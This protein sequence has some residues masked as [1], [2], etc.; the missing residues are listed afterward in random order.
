MTDGHDI[1]FLESPFGLHKPSR[2]T[3]LRSYEMR[4]SEYPVRVHTMGLT[5]SMDG[6]SP[7]ST[8]P[9]FFFRLIARSIRDWRDRGCTI[10][11]IVSFSS[12]LI[13]NVVIQEK[14]K[15]KREGIIRR[16]A[17]ADVAWRG[18]VSGGGV[19][20]VWVIMAMTHHSRVK[21]I[22]SFRWWY[23]VR[24]CVQLSV[25]VQTGC[26]SHGVLLLSLLLLLLLL[27][28]SSLCCVVFDEKVC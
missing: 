20:M 19:K 14:K 13:V 26:P 28:L 23:G 16:Y 1:S 4:I 24:E 21:N 22:S 17:S 6:R 5:R 10:W 2:F 9:F 18:T 25:R 11:S 3:I 12:F 7:Q 8:G 15:E 27:L